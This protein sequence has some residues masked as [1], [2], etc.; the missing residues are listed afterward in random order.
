M[1]SDDSPVPARRQTLHLALR[2]WS[3]RRGLRS[4]HD[5]SSASADFVVPV[6]AVYF[7]DYADPVG[8]QRA[9]VLAFCD[10]EPVLETDEIS[11]AHLN[12]LRLRLPSSLQWLSL[13]IVPITLSVALSM[14]WQDS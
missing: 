9:V 12:C 7:A 4:D 8:L 6:R 13:F 14:L 5:P 3:R 11:L 2:L 1:C 10:R